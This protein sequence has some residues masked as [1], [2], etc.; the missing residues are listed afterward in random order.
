MFLRP[1][2][3]RLTAWLAALALILGSLLPV[4]SHAVVVAPAGGQG[5]VEV[6]T[7]SGMAWVRQVPDDAGAASDSQHSKPGSGA[8]MDRCGWCATHSPMAGLPPVTGPLMGPV[9]LGADVP[10]AFRHAPRPLL[11]W[12]GAHSRA[13]PVAA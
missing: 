10:A 3:R 7:V 6:C 9:T 12:A 5:W 13:P 4:V 8:L 1:A 11:V 2:Q